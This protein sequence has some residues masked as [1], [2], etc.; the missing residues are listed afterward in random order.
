[1]QLDVQQARPQAPRSADPEF[2]GVVK[3]DRETGTVTIRMEDGSWEF[4][5]APRHVSLYSCLLYTSRCV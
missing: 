5:V 4:D 2:L 1:M 3:I